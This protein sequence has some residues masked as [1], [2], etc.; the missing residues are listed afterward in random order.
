MLQIKPARLA[1]GRYLRTYLPC[2]LKCHGFCREKAFMAVEE[3][4]KNNNFIRTE[5]TLY[6]SRTQ[7][8]VSE[9]APVSGFCKVARFLVT[10]ALNT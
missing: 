4:K 7:T 5:C 3:V 10:T 9:A 1:F 8:Q 6:V 2:M